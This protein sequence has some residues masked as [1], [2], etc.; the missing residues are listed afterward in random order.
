MI[1]ITNEQKEQMAS[2]WGSMITN[3]PQ[4]FVVK[5][6]YD[7][8]QQEIEKLNN[9]IKELD[10]YIDEHTEFNHDGDDYGYMEWYD[11]KGVDLTT[12]ISD[13]KDILRKSDK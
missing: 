5:E 9:I 2:F 12:F 1:E 10:D 6:K 8:L 7:E 13:I 4:E 3:E 11:T